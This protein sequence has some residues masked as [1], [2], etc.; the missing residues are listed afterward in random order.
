MATR[1][2]RTLEKS[3]AIRINDETYDFIAKK[4]AEKKITKSAYLLSQLDKNSELALFIVEDEKR[5]F[6]VKKEIIAQ[7]NEL[8]KSIKTSIIEDLNLVSKKEMKLSEF[9]YIYSNYINEP[10]FKNWMIMRA[11]KVGVNIE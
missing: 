1:I 6:I 2:K 5:Q 11:R 4:S 9:K 3:V 10:G 7:I 8:R